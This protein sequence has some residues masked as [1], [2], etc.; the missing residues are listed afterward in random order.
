MLVKQV[1]T[2]RNDKTAVEKVDARVEDKRGRVGDVVLGKDG[3][4]WITVQNRV[5]MQL[6]PEGGQIFEWISHA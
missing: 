6:A 4:P 3:I 5:G 2:G 1:D